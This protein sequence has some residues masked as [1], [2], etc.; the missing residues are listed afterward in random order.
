MLRFQVTYKEQYIIRLDIGLERSNAKANWGG[1]GPINS[2]L[3]VALGKKD[4]D[5]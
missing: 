4:D 3:T 1:H 5:P 2:L